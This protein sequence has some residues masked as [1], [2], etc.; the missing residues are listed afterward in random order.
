METLKE[1]LLHLQSSNTKLR[2]STKLPKRKTN[3]FKAR[4]S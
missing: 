3:Q 1:K 2:R 4:R